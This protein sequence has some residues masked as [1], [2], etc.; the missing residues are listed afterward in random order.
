MTYCFTDTETLGLSLHHDVWE[1]A[2]TIDGDK[3][4]SGF[5]RHDLTAADPE[6]L[7]VN[8]YRKRMTVGEITPTFEEDSLEVLRSYR[9]AGNAVVLVGANPSFDAYRLARRWGGEE[10]WHYRMVDVSVYAM[11]LVGAAAPL[12][13]NKTAEELRRRGYDIPEPD[14]TAAGDVDCIRECFYA[15]QALYSQGAPIHGH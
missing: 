1:W 3:I 13:L 6:A 12:G 10:P 15:L 4:R 14:H 9:R 11:P 7:L 2:W 5:L 8:G